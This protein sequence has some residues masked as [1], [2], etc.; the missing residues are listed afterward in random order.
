VKAISTAAGRGLK[1]PIFWN[2][3]GYENV[4][5]IRLLDGIVDIYK[6]DMKYG[7]SEAA[8]K[9]SNA[10]DYFERCKEAVR[11]MHRQVGDLKVDES[12]IAYRG[13]LIRH[14][15][16]PNDLAGSEKVLDFVADEISKDSYVNIMAQYRP[17]GRAYEYQELNRRPTSI[18]YSKAVNYARRVGLHRGFGGP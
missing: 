5:T 3:S 8:K 17:C 13:L 16:L 18:E 2:C 12:G 14:L 4:D 6:P 15:V 11:E 1:V 7:E 9:Y 10:S